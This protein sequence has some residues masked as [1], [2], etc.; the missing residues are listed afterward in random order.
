MTL[1]PEIKRR[2]DAWWDDAGEMARL[3]PRVKKNDFAAIVAH[4]AHEA[5]VSPPRRKPTKQLKG[6]SR[7]VSK[8]IGHIF[9]I[10]F[11]DSHFDRDLAVRDRLE[12][13]AGFRDAIDQYASSLQLG[14]SRA[15]AGG[16]VASRLF[17]RRK[18]LAVAAVYQHLTRPDVAVT[19]TLDPSGPFIM[20]ST[21]AVD[22][23]TGIEPTEAS[24]IKICGEFLDYHE[25]PRRR[26][27]PRRR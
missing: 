19:P 23:A 15:G 4:V 20:L 18:E 27:R 24:M 5:M 13:L 26:R 1:S 9:D 17:R 3:T 16:G 10:K 6:L 12:W 2:L 7:D 21:A 14:A 8:M 11:L 22:I 25:M